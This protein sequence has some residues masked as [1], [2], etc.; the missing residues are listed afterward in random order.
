MLTEQQLGRSQDRNLVTNL[1]NQ[2]HYGWTM[3]R[4]EA[5]EKK[6]ASLTA[7][8]VNAAAKK[9]IDPASFSIV[10]AGD[11]KKAGVT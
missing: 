6:V 3:L 2:A 4:T 5:I 1:A 9:W 11:F 8:D 7:A 10:K